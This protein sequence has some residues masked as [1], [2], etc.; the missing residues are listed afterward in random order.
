MEMMR[1]VKK[2]VVGNPERHSG[3]E[4]LTRGGYCSG[5]D[6]KYWT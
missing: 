1:I 5:C 6:S 4:D 3:V 2:V